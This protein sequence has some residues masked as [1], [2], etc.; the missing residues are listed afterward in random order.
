MADR[1]SQIGGDK[2]HAEQQAVSQ[3][4]VDD[5]GDVHEAIFDDGIRGCCDVNRDCVSAK[6]VEHGDIDVVDEE[7]IRA[8][9][10]VSQ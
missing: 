7:E 10:N 8:S 3:A 4:F 5:D 1:N 2:N 6:W 9:A